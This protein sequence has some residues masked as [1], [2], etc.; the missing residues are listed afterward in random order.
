[1]GRRC[2]DVTY[3]AQRLS[4]LHGED[5]TVIPQRSLDVKTEDEQEDI[6]PNVKVKEEKSDELCI[7]ERPRPT[8]KAT[9][10]K[11]NRFNQYNEFCRLF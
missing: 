11:G 3:L 10:R 5:W 1:M 6:K 9:K 4:T 8:K 7:D 2:K